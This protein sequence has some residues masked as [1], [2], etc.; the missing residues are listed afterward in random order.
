[1]QEET[2]TTTT[3]R[4]ENRGQLSITKNLLVLIGFLIVLFYV[5][6]L[7]LVY[8][9]VSEKFQKIFNDKQR[10]ASLLANLTTP[11]GFLN[12]K[13]YEF[14]DNLGITLSCLNFDSNLNF[15]QY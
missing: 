5:F 11:S 10:E 9:V 7:G 2:T 6:S 14:L 15:I 12:S 13:T 1:M 3:S 8:F 4:V